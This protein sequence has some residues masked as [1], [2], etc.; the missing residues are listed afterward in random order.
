MNDDKQRV[1]KKDMCAGCMLCID[2]CPV[3]AISLKDSI[4]AYNA[5]IDLNRC[6]KCGKR[7]TKIS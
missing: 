7:T 1:C 4:D 6:I 2:T 3:C 5:I